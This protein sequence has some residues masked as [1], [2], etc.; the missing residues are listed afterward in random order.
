MYQLAK[1][2]EREALFINTAAQM[3]IDAAIVE[4]D[5]WV[6]LTLDYL[7]HASKWKDSFAFKGGTSLSKVYNLIE[8]FSEDIDLILDWRVL[9]YK[10]DEP[11]ENRSNTQQHKFI[12]DSRKRL[13]FFLSDEFLPAFKKDM[14]NILDRKVNIFISEDDAVRLP[15]LLEQVAEFKQKF[16][17]RGWARYDLARMGTLKLYP[18][19]HSI[20]EIRKDYAKMRNMIYGE[21]PDLDTILESIKALEKEINR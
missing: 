16:Y 10:K 8:R 9:G 1:D 11:W 17:P 14:E 7:F 5:F 6:C 4:K 19:A 2:D 15:Q 21:Y 12:E 20:T 13:F 3:G 18:A